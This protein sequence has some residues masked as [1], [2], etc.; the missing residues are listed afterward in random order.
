MGGNTS[1]E[2]EQVNMD[3]KSLDDRNTQQEETK[4]QKE[5]STI[6]QPIQKKWWFWLVIVLVVLIVIAGITIGLIFGLRSNSNTTSRPRTSGSRTNSSLPQP[7]CSASNPAGLCYCVGSTGFIDALVGA[8]TN[9]TAGF[10]GDGGSAINAQIDIARV[11]AFDNNRCCLYIADVGNNRVRRVDLRANPPT[12]STVVGSGT[13][14]PFPVLSTPTNTNLAAISGLCVLQ[15]GS[16][17]IG[18]T[19]I[20]NNINGAIILRFDPQANTINFFSSQNVT[21]TSSGNTVSQA[22]FRATNPIVSDNQGNVY[23]GDT[24][25]IRR[26]NPTSGSIS[27]SST[28]TNFA[29]NGNNTA[30][31]LPTL[32]GA[33]GSILSLDI[34]NNGNLYALCLQSSTYVILRFNP[35]GAATVYRSSFSSVPFNIAINRL[36]NQLWF[37][38][39]TRGLYSLPLNDGTVAPTARCP[40]GDL[41][42]VGVLATSTTYGSVFPITF[43]NFGNCYCTIFVGG[44]PAL[45]AIRKI[46]TFQLT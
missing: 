41:G 46:T 14:A 40:P 42:S 22:T 21:G 29:G 32:N 18:Q 30:P 39:L 19:V 10:S 2:Y 45:S 8:A 34:D 4:N 13:Q 9:P 15:D 43:D 33:T 23:I 17:L 11:T 12:I 26:I 24:N 35:T 5:M 16:V 36:N 31:F 3:E 7:T 37:T 20:Q 1:R 27:G 38:D 28:I 6:K 44:S 25:L